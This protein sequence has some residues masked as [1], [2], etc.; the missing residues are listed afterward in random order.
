MLY[1]VT[2]C[3]T[4]LCCTLP[5]TALPLGVTTTTLLYFSPSHLSGAQT[6]TLQCT[7]NPC[8]AL[9]PLKKQ[10]Q[11]SDTFFQMCLSL[12]CQELHH[13]S[14]PRTKYFISA[15][16]TA[17]L[18]SDLFHYYQNYI[19]VMCQERCINILFSDQKHCA[20]PNFDMS[21]ISI[22]HHSNN[23]AYDIYN[24]CWNT[25]PYQEPFWCASLYHDKY[26]IDVL[27]PITVPLITMVIKK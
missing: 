13:W 20:M 10:P 23:R 2:S 1:Y 18:H 3:N 21:I 22:L 6:A 4:S 11:K 16:I 5:H 17:A 15:P 12:L 19:T 7:N 27:C 8:I 24:K 9:Y 25:T 26:I 14:K